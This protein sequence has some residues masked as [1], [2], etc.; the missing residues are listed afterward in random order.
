M[1]NK[2]KKKQIKPIWI[3]TGLVALDIIIDDINNS[4][5]QLLS[6]GSCGNV[7]SIMSYLGFESYV[8]S[9]LKNNLATKAVIK[10]LK[11]WNVKTKLVTV[12]SDGSTPIII[13]RNKRNKLGE[14]IHKFEF[15]DPIDGAWLPNYK[16]VLSADV[17]EIV[18]KTSEPVIYYFDRINRGSIDFAKYYKSKGA[19]I[20]FEPSSIGEMRL[21][22]ECLKV[23]DIIKFSVD[24][25]SNY[26]ELFPVQRVPLEIQ[27]Q[28]DKGINYRFSHTLKEK[29]WVNLKSFSI[30]CLVDASGAGDWM[31]AGLLTKVGKQGLKGFSNIDQKKV[32]EALKFGQALGSLNCFYTGA[33]GLM[34]QCTKN[35]VENLVKQLQKTKGTYSLTTKTG[36][37]KRQTNLDI[38]K[39]YK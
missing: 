35:Q 11:K 19:L 4:P 3:G 2:I 29:K 12:T 9:R 33:R 6:G 24:R 27:T 25:I 16:P 36:N 20:Y 10:D 13:Q 39:L 8:I 37:K 18:K 30:S 21:F 5:E 28:G 22:E 14:P 7:S 31:S 34:Y 26:S 1:E 23:A 38:G 15:K 17:P 32:V